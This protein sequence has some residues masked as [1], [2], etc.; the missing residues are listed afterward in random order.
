[1]ASWWGRAAA[2]A[3][4][5]AQSDYAK[6][7][8]PQYVDGRSRVRSDGPLS[9]QSIRTQGAESAINLVGFSD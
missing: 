2:A 6:T 1:M 7:F 8:K 4:S 9:K 3:V 5:A